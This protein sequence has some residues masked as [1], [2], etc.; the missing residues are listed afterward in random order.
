MNPDTESTARTLVADGKRILAANETPDTWSCP[1][2]IDGKRTEDS[3]RAHQ[4]PMGE[5][6]ENLA[7][8][9]ILEQWMKSYKP[10]ELARL[11][12]HTIPAA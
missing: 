11:D 1:K 4:V 9:H 3:W 2:E 7:H 8:V 10:E 6:Q 5:M 12:G